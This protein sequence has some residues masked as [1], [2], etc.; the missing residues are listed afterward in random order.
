MLVFLAGHCFAEEASPPPSFTVDVT[1]T[2]AA[3]FSDWIEDYL[4]SQKVGDPVSTIE[5]VTFARDLI[6]R[7]HRAEVTRFAFRINANHDYMLD[8]KS[9]FQGD[10]VWI[11]N[12]TILGHDDNSEA[13]IFVKD[14]GSIAGDL[15]IQGTGTF[16]I[17]PTNEL[18]YHIVYLRTGSFS[19]D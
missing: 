9:V 6:E 12:C 11:L 13:R 15:F 7:L 19:I 17:T 4:S 16:I 3:K 2:S 18:P 1:E 8:R 14:D 10:G 5:V